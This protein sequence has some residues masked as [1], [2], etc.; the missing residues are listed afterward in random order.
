MEMPVVNLD[1]EVISLAKYSSTGA[2]LWAFKIGGT[3]KDHVFEIAVDASGVYLSGFFRFTADIDP[4]AGT[5]ILDD[6]NGTAFLAKYDPSGA[7]QWGFNFGMTATD[8]GARDIKIDPTGNI[9][10]TGFFRGTNMDFDPG[11]GTALLSATGFE[12]FVAKYNSAGQYICA[13]KIGG[14]LDDFGNGLTIDNA[15]DIYV[16]GEFQA[17]N[18]DF[19]P[20]A[21][22][23]LRSSNGGNDIFV[24][25]YNSAGQYQWALSAGSASNEF[26]RHIINDN[27]SVYIVYT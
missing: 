10:I 12:A 22:T 21:G 26:S 14:S 13:F 4:G 18:V 23:A 16:T 11:P 2:F 3:Q 19:D 24:A 25:K 9:V 27:N 20:S 8:N 5:T 7:F 15:G 6:V 17:T 1:L